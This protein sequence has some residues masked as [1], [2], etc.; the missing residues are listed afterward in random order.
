MFFGF[1]YFDEMYSVLDHIWRNPVQQ[2]VLNRSIPDYAN[3]EFIQRSQEQ[4]MEA[5]RK[6]TEFKMDSDR[7]LAEQQFKQQ[8][9]RA[10]ISANEF[11]RQ[12]ETLNSQPPLYPS[13]G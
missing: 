7:L 5:L 13:L 10:P 9:Q 4:Q 12:Q 3:F 8:Q 6:I 1:K 2:F 11:L